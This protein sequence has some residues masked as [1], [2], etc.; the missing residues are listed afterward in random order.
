MPRRGAKTA[1]VFSFAEARLARRL[2]TYRQ[3]LDTVLRSNRKAIGTLYTTGSLFTKVGTRAGRDLL[4]AHEHL[5]RVVALLDQLGHAGDVPAPT[6]A[7]EV[8]A[9]FTELDTLLT[10]TGELTEQT[11]ELVADLKPKPER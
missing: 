11:Q 6:S 2:S 1:E 4:T 3:R 9:I 10:R 8:E 7:K 5:L